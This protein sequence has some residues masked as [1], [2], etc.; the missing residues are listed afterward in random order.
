MSMSLFV[1]LALEK[2]PDAAYLNTKAEQ[3]N[4]DITYEESID[5]DSH[6]GFYPL[7]LNGSKSGFELYKIEFK[8]LVEK[9]PH[10][11]VNLPDNGVVYLLSY[12][13]SH[14]EAPAAFYTAAILSTTI[15]GVVFEPQGG[16]YMTTDELLKEAKMLLTNE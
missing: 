7:I 14:N 10:E 5:F 11:G 1:V 6:S 16:K 2:A 3:F 13:F 12:G 8:E 9:L 15:N 4:L